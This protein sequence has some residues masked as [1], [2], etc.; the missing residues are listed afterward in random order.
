MSESTQSQRTKVLQSIFQGYEGP[1][2]SIRLWDGWRWQ[3]PAKGEPA[4]TIV[5]H[6]EHALQALVVHPSEITLGEA[7]LS[8]DIDVEEDIFSVFAL[9]EYL[10]QCPR[11]Q[12]QRLM[13]FLSGSV[14]QSHE[15]RAPI[16]LV[17]AIR[18]RASRESALSRCSDSS[19]RRQ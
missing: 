8:K 17:A 15:P 18:S 7:F 6:S 13:E 19:G 5:F 10:F 11:G 9:T 12:R 3:S 16:T 2:F 4:C 14:R 1:P